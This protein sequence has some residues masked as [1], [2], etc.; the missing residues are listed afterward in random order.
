[1][2]NPTLFEE[3][4]LKDPEEEVMTAFG[5]VYRAQLIMKV[6]DLLKDST[7]FQVAVAVTPYLCPCIRS[8]LSPYYSI[9][10]MVFFPFT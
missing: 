7:P 9:L 5:L 3:L 1:M 8:F 4:L 10:L 6:L 2:E